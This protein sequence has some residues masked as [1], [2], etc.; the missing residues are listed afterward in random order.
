MYNKTNN[1]KNKRKSIINLS[2]YIKII[3]IKAEMFM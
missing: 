2:D 3:V 1:N